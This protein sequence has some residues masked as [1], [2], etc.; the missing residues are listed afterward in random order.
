ML[1]LPRPF[2]IY[3][4]EGKEVR[5]ILEKPCTCDLKDKGKVLPCVLCNDTGYVLT[6]EGKQFIQFIQCYFKHILPNV[7]TLAKFLD[8]FQVSMYHRK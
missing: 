1:A 5:L 3:T 8:V 7:E 6:H 2:E 4:E